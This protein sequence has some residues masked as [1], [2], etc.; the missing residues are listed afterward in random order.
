MI[1][2][3]AEKIAWL[4]RCQLDELSVGNGGDSASNRRQFLSDNVIG[5]SSLVGRLA[6]VVAEASRVSA[7]M[8]A[9]AL[10]F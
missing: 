5:D 2:L 10:F 9:A 4:I 1:P 7:A 3:D 8:S 6:A